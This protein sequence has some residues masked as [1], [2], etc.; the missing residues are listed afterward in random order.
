MLNIETLITNSSLDIQIKQKLLTSIEDVKTKQTTRTTSGFITDIAKSF[1]NQNS[2][3]IESSGII[4]EIL[5]QKNFKIIDFLLN[6]KIIG[7]YFMLGFLVFFGWMIPIFAT[8][9]IIFH[10]KA[11]MHWK[12]YYFFLIMLA[13]LAYYRFLWKKLMP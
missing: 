8:K 12:Y 9:N 10:G 1:A 2:A 4:P 11:I 6:T 5:M 3:L 13:Q 7:V